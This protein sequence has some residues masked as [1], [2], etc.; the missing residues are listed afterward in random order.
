MNH[1]QTNIALSTLFLY[2]TDNCNLSCSHCWISPSY[3]K[4]K[5][6]GI[7][8]DRLKKAISEAKALGLAT[9]KLTGGEPLLYKELSALL[10]FLA[11]EK[12]TVYIETNGTLIDQ[13]V[14]ETFKDCRVQQ[15]SVSL[16]AA[17][18]QIHDDIRGIKGGFA[19]AVR[20]LQLL[21]SSGL[22]FQIIMTLQHKNR[23]EIPGM[24]LL[25][26]KLGARSLKINHLVPC[27]RGKEAF[28]RKQNLKLNELVQ[29]YRMV[30]NEWSARNKLDIIFDIPAAFRSLEELKQRG[31][32]ECNILNILGILAN[33]EFSICGIGQTIKELRMGHVNDDAI[34]Y[35]WQN[36][37]ILKEL[38]ASLPSKLNGICG[39]CIFKFQ[40]LGACRANAYAL[41]SD[42]FAPYFLCQELFESGLFPPSRQISK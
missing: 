40:C 9:V 34:C 25:S 4:N 16:D 8:V 21:A 15:I 41:T 32:F 3:S 14:L 7:S 13:A 29:L 27:G 36:N 10:T 26:E 20:G 38:R 6:A 19:D 33:G 18:E 39:Q 22:N 37:D 11:N 35:I 30:Q 1:H 5:Q 28:K 31:V 24:I 23:L 17:S 12:L 42:L 2:L